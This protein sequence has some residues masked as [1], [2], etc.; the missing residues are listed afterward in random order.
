V[1]TWDRLSGPSECSSVDEEVLKSVLKSAGNLYAQAGIMLIAGNLCFPPKTVLRL[2]AN[3]MTISN[4]FCQVVFGLRPSGSVSF[5]EPGTG[6]DVPQ[7]AS[8]ESRYETR[9]VGIV[10]STEFMALRAQHRDMPKYRAW[11]TRLVDGTRE[12][13]EGPR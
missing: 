7:L 13:F 6:G 5:M 3:T 8:G 10:I 9:L 2:T 1:T 12:W 11:A 4:P